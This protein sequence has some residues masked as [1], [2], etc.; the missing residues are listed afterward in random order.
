MKKISACLVMLAMLIIIVG[1][2]EK[3]QRCTRLPTGGKYCL[4]PTTV[5]DAFDAQQLVEA[6][7]NG[8]KET[9]IFEMESDAT[10]LRFAG[11]TPLGNKV[12]Q[13]N[14]NNLETT[15]LMLPTQKLDPVLMVALVQL[16]LW[17]ADSVR[18]GLKGSL[19]LEETK[20][21]RRILNGD[22]TLLSVRRFGDK[23]PYSRLQ[24]TIPSV[25]LELNIK[26][27]STTQ[28][29]EKNR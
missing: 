12:L 14:Y 8:H 19:K 21:T 13:I 6:T 18:T 7:L 11:M 5:L 10:G 24:M 9:M 26:T 29:T 27:L 17:P 4:Q 3:D 20:D 1:C 25:E 23:P 2:N 22:E 15:A 16:T 28:T